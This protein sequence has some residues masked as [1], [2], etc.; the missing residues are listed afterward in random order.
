MT[1]VQVCLAPLPVLPTKNKLTRKTALEIVGGSLSNV[2]K[3]PTLS[4]GIS[5]A[6]CNIGQ[7]LA[8]IANT[9]CSICYADRKNSRYNQPSVRKAHAR[10]L[11]ALKNPRWVDAM[12][13]LIRSYK[14]D[15][16][17]WFDSGDLQGIPHLQQIV[18]IANQLPDV[19]FWLPTQER[20]LVHQYRKIYGNEPDNLVIRFSAMY[21]DQLDSKYS[22]SSSALNPDLYHATK[23]TPSHMRCPVYQKTKD[24]PTYG[25]C[26]TCRMCWDRSIKHIYYQQH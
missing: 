15:C 11:E 21:F 25:K 22:N 24:D 19:K 14:L 8:K 18:S 6:K 10:R 23:D 5:T 3:M 1:D 13:F 4:W 12:V 9:V 2:F 7:T 16:F 20:N 17:R 26:D